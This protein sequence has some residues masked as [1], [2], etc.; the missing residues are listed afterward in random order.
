MKTIR[1]IQKYFPNVRSEKARIMDK[2]SIADDDSYESIKIYTQ[3][4]LLVG[5]SGIMKSKL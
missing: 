4:E 5:K 2:K 3:R 1:E